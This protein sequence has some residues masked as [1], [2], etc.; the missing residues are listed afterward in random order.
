VT[1]FGLSRELW[2]VEFGIFVNMLGYG[3]VLPFEII[4][5]H[6]G[7][8]FGLAVA[9][10][11]VGAITGAAVVT[12]PVAGPLIDRFGARTAAVGAS[13]ALAA[14][15]AGLAIATTP[16]VAVVAACIA[17]A[18]NGV[19]NPSQSTL[20]AN[21]S[22][23]DVRHRATA[24]S[25]VAANVGFGLGGTLGGFVAVRGLPGFVALFLGNAVTYLLY[26]AVL[27]M[28][29][30]ETPS[31]PAERGYSVVLRD[32]TFLRLVA[33]NVAMIA[34]GWSVFSW[35][36][37][38]HANAMHVSARL[39]G[40]LLLANAATVV[41]LQVPI[42][43]YAEGRRRALMIVIAAGLFAGACV[44]VAG[45]GSL[46]RWAYAILVVAT[47]LV[48]LGECFHTSALMPLVAD[49][50]PVS[51]RG[52]YMAV[53]GFSWWIGLAVAP[54]LGPALLGAAPSAA[55]VVSGVVAIGAGA[56]ALG[57]ERRLPEAAVRTPVPVKVTHG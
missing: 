27:V 46:G 51:L 37:P 22:T 39:I 24:V 49:L 17:G 16:A 47:V 12:A 2:L 42:A 54:M 6:D 45:A 34:V 48:G 11:V 14:G 13:V 31:P 53:M 30:R 25:R 4:Y 19:A 9:G 26:I 10:L 44:L 35:L 28:A 1:F 52:R 40:V 41:A 38:L 43:K 3:A 36:L 29:V 21:M 33:V 15:Y 32:R 18:G 8:G 57:L 23:R 56:V 20:I 5:L 55:F 7:R 50:A